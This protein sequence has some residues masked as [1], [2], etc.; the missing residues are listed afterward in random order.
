MAAAEVLLAEALADALLADALADELAALLEALL[1][2]PASTVPAPTAATTAALPV[3]NER[4]ESFE[5]CSDIL[6][7]SFQTLPL[8]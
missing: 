5:S 8:G 1:P 3:I 2:Q 7:P 6:L 4:R